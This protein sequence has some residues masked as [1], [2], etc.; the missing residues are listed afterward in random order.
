MTRK[1][2]PQRSVAVPKIRRSR[3]KKPAPG[4]LPG[5]L[6]IPESPGEVLLT[7]LEY[8]RES[9]SFDVV[10][11]DH[12]EAALEPKPGSVVWVEVRGS[13]NAELISR[14]GTKL[15]LDPLTLED[16]AHI[17]QRPKIEEF[18]NYVFLTLRGI[19][20][21]DETQIENEQVSFVLA[22]SVLITFQ[23]R[24]GDPFEPVRRR[25]QE[26]RGV[27]GSRGADYLFYALLDVIIDHYFPVVEVYGDSLD[28]LEE[29]IRQNPLPSHSQ[30][31]HAL[32]RELRQLRRAAWP[33][34]E[35]LNRL[36]RTEVKGF[37]P[38]LGSSFRDCA[39]HL[40]QAADFIEGSRERAGDMGDLYQSMV[41]E[42]TNQ[43]MKMLTIIS[44]IFIP[45]SFLCGLYGMNFNTEASPWNMPELNW[46][47]GYPVFIG[48]LLTLG[49]GML[50]MFGKRGWLGET[51]VGGPGDG[52]EP[53]K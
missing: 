21:T 19:R 44:T 10:P 48:L 46:R 1:S 12:L 16:I 35:V 47:Y 24:P 50:W 5:T 52:A 4:A 7:R 51:G 41:G 17:H 8:G 29:S 11:I 40:M 14:I 38:E 6:V 49:L 22:G 45:L 18:G 27:I 2:K 34:R 33:L 28:Q 42:K 31:L 26:G 43:V 30:A 37:S 15:A 13:G 20:K 3:V 9:L 53:E 39:D 23:E 32:R 25:L 36:S